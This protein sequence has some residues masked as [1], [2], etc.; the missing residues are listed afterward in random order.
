METFNKYQF[1]EDLSSIITKGINN[2]EINSSDD[3]YT[4]MHEEIE[5]ECIYYSN[6]FDICKELNATDFTA[7][8]M[9]CNTI[10]ELAYAALYQYTIDE[11]DVNK[12]EQ[13][14]ETINA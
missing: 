2:G 1:I 6:C 12:L 3:Y 9:E 5:R 4:L 8:D 14:L 13:L 11:L 7:Y 10:S